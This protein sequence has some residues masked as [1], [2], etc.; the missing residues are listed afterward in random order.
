MPSNV[1]FQGGQSRFRSLGNNQDPQTVMTEE[2]VFL[3]HL[4]NDREPK[5]D[6][7]TTMNEFNDHTG[8]NFRIPALQMR[9]SRLKERLRVW[10]EKDVSAAQ[11]SD[12]A[13]GDIEVNIN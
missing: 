7:K 5:P 11:Q 1:E 8:K 6:W 2:E 3:L 13:W 4:R 10:S 9:Y 12:V